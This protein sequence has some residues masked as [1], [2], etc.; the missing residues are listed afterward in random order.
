MISNSYCNDL[1]LSAEVGRQT[2]SISKNKLYFYRITKGLSTDACFLSMKEDICVGLKES[3]DYYFKIL[4]PT[5][6]YKVEKDTLFVYTSLPANPPGKFGVNVT[7]VEINSHESQKYQQLFQEGKI[8]KV[9]IDS[10][11]AQKCAIKY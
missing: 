7:Q 8:Q 5:I 6:Y 10:T 9:E 1:D 11:Y 4:D 2:V 3:E